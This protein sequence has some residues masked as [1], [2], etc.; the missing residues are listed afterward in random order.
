MLKRLVLIILIFSTCMAFTSCSFLS[1]LFQNGD[2]P[3]PDDIEEN[4]STD[5]P[6]DKDIFS[7]TSGGK[8]V[9]SLVMPYSVSDT[10]KPEL[11][12]LKAALSLK[13]IELNVKYETDNDPSTAE[14]LVGNKI[15]A[16]GDYYID[17]HSLGDEGYVIRVTDGKLIVA[18]GS[19]AALADAISMLRLDILELDGSDTDVGN[20][21]ISIS[22]DIT[23]RQEYSIKSISIQGIDLSEYVIFGD[24]ADRNVYSSVT[25]LR[26][27]L[28]SESGYWLEI[29]NKETDRMIRLDIVDDAGE[30]GFRVMTD[31]E[32]LVIECA[33]S[34]LLQECVEAFIG[35]TLLPDHER[36]I[37][38]GSDYLYTRYIKSIGYC[39]Y[40][41]AVGDGVTVD[42]SA[43]KATHDRANKTGQTVVAESGKT[44]NLGIG[45]YQIEIKTD[46]VWTGATFII[47]DREVP[48]DSVHRTRNLFAV[49]SDSPQVSVSGIASLKAGQENMGVTFDNDVLLYIVDETKKQYIRY[50]LNQ[51]D[52]AAQQEV[53]LVDKDGNVDPSTPILWDYSEVSSAIAY[54]ASDKPITIDGGTF[55]TYANQ[56]P[57]RYTYFNR[58]ILIS[59]SN[60]TIKNMTHLVEGEGDHGAPYA[61]FHNIS[62]CSNVLFDNVVYTAHKTYRLE[63]NTANSMGT[64][65]F[66]ANNAINITWRNCRQ[67]ND[68]NDTAYW[69]IMGSNY[70][71][72]ITY[73]S[74]SF[75]RMDAHKGTHNATVKDSEIGH[76]HISIIGSGT[77]LIENTTVYGNSVI[78]L[79]G[80]YGST[81][82]GDVIL[83]NINLVNTSYFPRLI[84]GSWY[85]HYFGYQ[86][87][88][89]TTV[90]IDGIT[91]AVG[92]SFSIL[93]SISSSALTSTVNPI[94]VT[95]KIII[96][97]N[98]NGYTYS[99]QQVNTGVFN[100]TELVDMSSSTSY[101]FIEKNKKAIDKLISK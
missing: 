74:C 60:T 56:A 94:A 58:G 49:V 89:P 28:Y 68:I 32:H 93:P 95:E 48:V 52:G 3:T 63:T 79:R 45:I 25:L 76:Q 27:A 66:N 7:I 4:I 19:D 46:T 16:R 12:A 37:D 50:G 38:F 14:I 82:H 11:D 39:S 72:N 55:I 84:N 87:Y 96:A 34:L 24:S 54:S 65:D 70:C 44:F 36:S 5:T 42:I 1:E 86:C 23:K 59:R 101:C 20:L 85:N 13:G 62:F 98:P 21:S 41:G 88:M 9:A 31:R 92:N 97:S 80:D 18:A 53:I 30:D 40:G 73:E 64:Y 75:S 2:K 10:V 57:S 91:L 22:T 15:G 17:P 43:I 35:D 100:S 78:E 83:R 51:D 61:G 8:P 77:L 81:W 29:T 47:D 26:D 33:Y 6:I 69:G 99:K 67:T 71:K 90:T